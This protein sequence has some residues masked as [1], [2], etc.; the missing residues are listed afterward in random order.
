M[1]V[2]CKEIDEKWRVVNAESERIETTEQGNPR[3]G[4]GHPTKEKCQRQAAAINMATETMH[5]AKQNI[6]QDKN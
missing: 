2:K 5:R 4:G 3:D 1:P 6:G